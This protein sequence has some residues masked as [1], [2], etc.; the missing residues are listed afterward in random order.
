MRLSK[1]AG[2]ETVWQFIPFRQNE[3]Q[4]NQVK[5]LA[6][7]WGVK[8]IFSI[9]NRFDGPDDPMLPFDSKLHTYN[10]T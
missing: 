5:E 9:S 3:N 2:L 4:I 7:K 1:E 6:D 10:L 8:L